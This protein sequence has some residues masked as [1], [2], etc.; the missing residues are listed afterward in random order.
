MFVVVFV[1]NAYFL[2]F[3]IR[4]VYKYGGYKKKAKGVIKQASFILKNTL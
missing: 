3:V 4:I 2:I 1:S